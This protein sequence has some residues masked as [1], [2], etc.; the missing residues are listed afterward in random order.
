MT[1]SDRALSQNNILSASQVF[2][3]VYTLNIPCKWYYQTLTGLSFH[4]FKNTCKHDQKDFTLG[5]YRGLGSAKAFRSSTRGPRPMPPQLGPTSSNLLNSSPKRNGSVASP[6]SIIQHR[7]HPQH[8]LNTTSILVQ[9]ATYIARADYEIHFRNSIRRRGLCIHGS[10]NSLSI[11][12]HCIHSL[13]LVFLR[14]GGVRCCIGVSL[15]RGNAGLRLGSRSLSKGTDWDFQHTLVNLILNAQATGGEPP[16]STMAISETEIVRLC[17]VCLHLAATK[18][19]RS[20]SRSSRLNFCQERLGPLPRQVATLHLRFYVIS[21]HTESQLSTL[22]SIDSLYAFDSEI[23]LT[24]R[25]LRKIRTTVVSTSSSPN[26]T[27][28]SNPSFANI[29]VSSSNIFAKPGQMENNDRTLKELATP[30]G[31]YQPCCIQYSQLEPDQ[32][33]EL[34]SVA[35]ISWSCRRRPPQTSEGIPCGLFHDEATG[36]IRRLHQ[37][38]GVPI[39]P[40][41]SSEGLAIS[42]TNA[43]QHLGRYEAH[44]LGKVLSDIQNHIHQKGDMWDKATY[45]RDFARVLGKVQQ[46]L[47]HLST[48]SDQRIYFC[49]GLLMMDKSMIDAAS[50]GALMDKMSATARHLISNMASNTQ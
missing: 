37:N 36:D 42:S 35:Q 39:L 30:D 12:S 27:I 23:E 13:A 19:D 24:L 41:R 22:S 34:K 26:S 32:T 11:H 28:N 7:G 47:C 20:L 43:F 46:T 10:S 38:E 48:P 18:S 40:G 2:R 49:E 15:D 9:S 14:Y 31:V 1:E 4:T 29:L 33:Y 25:R 50:G 16:P 17:S 21:L 44:I 5:L 45:R 8:Q 3:F 6:T